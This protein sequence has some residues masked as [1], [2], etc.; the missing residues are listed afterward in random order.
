MPDYA[1]NYSRI[2]Y[3]FSITYF[4]MAALMKKQVTSTVSR[5]STVMVQAA[6]KTVSKASKASSGSMVSTFTTATSTF[7]VHLVMEPD[8]NLRCRFLPCS[9]TAPSAWAT[10]APSVSIAFSS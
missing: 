9:G 1:H 7:T 10:W 6:K 3:L 2:P 4:E 5:R 8:S